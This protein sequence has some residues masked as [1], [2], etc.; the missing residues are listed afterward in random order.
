[1]EKTPWRKKEYAKVFLLYLA[2]EIDG[3]NDVININD[4]RN[5]DE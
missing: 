5:G 3:V 4:G 1:M 2:G